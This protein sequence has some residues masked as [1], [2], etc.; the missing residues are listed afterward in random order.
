MLPGPYINVCQG[1]TILVTLSNSLH[2]SEGTSIHWHGITQRG[3]PFMD[4]VSMITQCPVISRTSF[5]YKFVA[6]DSGTHFYHAHAGTQRADGVFG[7][8]IVHEYEKN[9]I[10][11]DKYDYDLPEHIVT[12]NDWINDTSIAKLTRILMLFLS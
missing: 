7:P 8:L 6:S 2:L 11:L 4:G 5:Q 3:T 12:M 10:H 1:D 9:N